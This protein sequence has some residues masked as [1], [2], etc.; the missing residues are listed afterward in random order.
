MGMRQALKEWAVVAEALAT[1][2]QLFIL[3]KGGI[4]EGKRGF[5]LQHPHF[6]LFPTWEHQHK[7]S[8]SPESYD[9]FTQLQPA[10]EGE[11]TIRYWSEAVDVLRAPENPQTLIDAGDLHIWTESYIRMR[12]NYRPDLPLWLITLKTHLL[13]SP[14]TIAN[15][16]FYRGCR[17]WVELS[18]EV[19]V[20]GSKPA[21][22]RYHFGTT[23]DQLLKRLD[24]RP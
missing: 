4:A 18:E 8:L 1:S 20:E 10:D 11:V 6:L 16:R 15:T 22:G 23:R 24:L 3:R 5:E 12:Y 21:L 17:S 14:A 9:L 19:A 2:R 7:E 13:P